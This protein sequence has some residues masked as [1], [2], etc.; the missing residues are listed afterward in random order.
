MKCLWVLCIRERS[1]KHDDSL[2]L[3]CYHFAHFDQ[4]RNEIQISPPPHPTPNNPWS[5]R[6]SAKFDAELH[7]SMA[8]KVF[9]SSFLMG[10]NYTVGG[11]FT[12]F[13]WDS[14][15]EEMAT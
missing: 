2:I 7:D 9:P 6:P 12:D 11:V 10:D 15:A 13:W 1:E 14:F 8:V 4:F 5:V 3:V